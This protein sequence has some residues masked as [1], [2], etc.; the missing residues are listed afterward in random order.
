MDKGE[1]STIAAGRPL[2]KDAER[3]RLLILEAAR[4]VF[5]QRGLDATLDEVAREAGLGVGT[6]YR[7]FPNRDALI[8]ALFTDVVD[9]IDRVVEES[10][11]MPRAWDGLRHFMGAMLELQCRDKG[12]R[13]SMLSGR[14]PG[15]EEHDLVRDRIKPLIY[16]LVLRAQQEGDL[17]ADVTPTDIGVLEIAA[18]GA[19][20]FTAAAGPEVWKRCLTVMMDGMRARPAGAAGNTPLD[21]EPLDDDQL[22]ACMVG[23]KYGSREVPRQQQRSA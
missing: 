19:A 21:Q 15:L 6:V 5:A 8:E 16:G 14:G 18:L 2:R 20:E 23:W 9:A 3:N 22:D 1:A 17:R 11:A 12:L 4:T 10:V 13:D 7:R